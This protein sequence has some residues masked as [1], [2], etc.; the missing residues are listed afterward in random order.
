MTSPTALRSLIREAWLS[1]IKPESARWGRSAARSSRCRPGRRP[2]SRPCGSGLRLKPAFHSQVGNTLLE[3]VMM[4]VAMRS[5]DPGLRLRRGRRRPARQCSCCWAALKTTAMHLQPAAAGSAVLGVC[6][7]PLG[8][9]AAD[10]KCSSTIRRDRL[11][12]VR[13]QRREDSLPVGRRGRWSS[14]CRGRAAPG[15]PVS[16]P[17]HRAV[18]LSHAWLE[19]RRPVHT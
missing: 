11:Q 13:Q 7:A 16:Q 17:E 15:R 19:D 9:A 14:V 4:G 18:V 6:A 8:G 3:A 12:S 2:D 10:G 1:L 5:A